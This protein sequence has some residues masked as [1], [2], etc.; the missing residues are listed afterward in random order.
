MGKLSPGN[1]IL[2]PGSVFR[3]SVWKFSIEPTCSFANGAT[4]GDVG[5]NKAC[6][7]CSLNVF[8]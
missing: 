8:W 1:P 2:L 4:I 5:N 3:I 6:K 7:L